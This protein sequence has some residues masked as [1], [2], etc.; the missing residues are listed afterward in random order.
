MSDAFNDEPGRD[1]RPASPFWVGMELRVV[2]KGR[3]TITVEFFDGKQYTSKRL[4]VL[5]E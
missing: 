5:D 2:Q 4:E 1:F 3:H